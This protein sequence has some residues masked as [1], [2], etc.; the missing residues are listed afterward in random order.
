MIDPA[1]A[2]EALLDEL[3]RQRAA[4]VTKVSVSPESLEFLRKVSG[5]AGPSAAAAKPVAND[6][7][8]VESPV[9]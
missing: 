9:A 1:D 6:S 7:R 2:I 8:R 4:G 3:K 5:T